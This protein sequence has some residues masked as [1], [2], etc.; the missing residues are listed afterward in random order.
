MSALGFVVGF[1]LLFLGVG[2]GDDA[3][4]C[5]DVGLVAF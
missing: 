1:H 2:V 4:A 5:L 3:C